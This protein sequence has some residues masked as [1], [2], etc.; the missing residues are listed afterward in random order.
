MINKKQYKPKA[1]IFD[2]DGTLSDPSHRVHLY[3]KGK[4][5]Q[6]N[7]ECHLDPAFEDVCK[8]CRELGNRNFKI[9]FLTARPEF[10][11]EKT[12]KWINEN[13]NFLINKYELIMR[14]ND[15]H[16]NSID[17]KFKK[18]P[19]LI[20]KYDIIGVFEDRENIVRMWRWQ[21]L[22]CFALPSL[23]D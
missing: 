22:T 2:I 7:E 8:L 14:E 4:I 1:Y 18:I 13:V 21:G 20:E 11:R 6:F 17:F 9:I 3:K 12:E 23:F 15:N 19:E 5:D 16:E 10:I